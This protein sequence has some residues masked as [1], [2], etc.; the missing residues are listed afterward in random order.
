MKRINLPLP[1]TFFFSGYV[2]GFGSGRSWLMAGS[3]LTGFALVALFYLVWTPI[4]RRRA[5]EAAREPMERLLD[6]M[7]RCLARS[8]RPLEE[9][10][11]FNAVRT[12]GNESRYVL[13]VDGADRQWKLETSTILEGPKTGMTRA[14]VSAYG[15]NDLLES[16]A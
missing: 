16:V 13:Q 15:A 7:L 3:V 14:C 9:I 5:A 4:A 8:E 10:V 11:L 2:L 6:E 1:F 12:R